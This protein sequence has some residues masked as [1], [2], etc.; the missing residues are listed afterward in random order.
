MADKEEKLIFILG[1][2]LSTIYDVAIS[3][4]SSTNKKTNS[5]GMKRCIKAYVT[6][7]IDV[8]VKSFGEKHI[9]S[10]TPITKK[11]EGIIKHYHTHVYLESKRTKPKHKHKRDVLEKSVRQLNQDW[12]SKF[13]SWSKHSK[14]TVNVSSLLDIGSNMDQ[15][16]GDEKAFYIDQKTILYA[17]PF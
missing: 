13:I 17:M 9:I 12:S 6:A 5:D 16:T 2:K 7:L 1:D 10:C 11:V 4:Y 15:L 14:E 8:W 3:I